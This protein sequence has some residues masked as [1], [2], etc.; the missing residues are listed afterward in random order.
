MISPI[1]QYIAITGFMLELLN[2]DWSSD[3][4]E[5]WDII[6]NYDK[7]VQTILVQASQKII[8]MPST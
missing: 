4:L 6:Q 3:N 1:S 2:S 8:L 5:G 7:N